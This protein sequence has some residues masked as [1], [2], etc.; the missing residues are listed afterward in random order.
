MGSYY[1]HRQRERVR[2]EAWDQASNILVSRR[3]LLVMNVVL[4]SSAPPRTETTLPV[5][6]PTP[7]PSLPLVETTAREEVLG[8]EGLILVP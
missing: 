3:P 7:V 8:A 5:L 2:E 4:G 1:P 6:P